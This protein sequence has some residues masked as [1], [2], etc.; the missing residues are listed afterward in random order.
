[1]CGEYVF[2]RIQPPR[3]DPTIF[4][5]AAALSFLETVLIFNQLQI[6]WQRVSKQPLIERENVAMKHL[7]ASLSVILLLLKRQ[8][9]SFRVFKQFL[10]A[11]TTVRILWFR[12]G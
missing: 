5:F 1:M 8:H 12:I 3:Q 6:F 7:D 9:K 2:I 10:T 4:T 11:M